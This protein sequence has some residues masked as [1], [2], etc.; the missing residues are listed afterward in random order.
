[1][2]G[3]NF[4]YLV[5]QGVVSVW[6]NRLMSFASFCIIMVSLLLISLAALIA[7]DINVVIGTAED[8]NEILVYVDD[9][10][11]EKIVKIEEALKNNGYTAQVVFYPK[12]E[13]LEAKKEELKEYADLLDALKDNP[14]PDT[15][16]VTIKDISKIDEAKRTFEAIE[17]VSEVSAPYD[18]ASVLVSLKTTLGIIGGAMLIALVVVCIVIVY[19]ASRTSVFARRKEI[20]IM[21]MVGATNS[22]IKLPFFIEGMFIGILAGAVSWFLTKIAYEA[23]ISFFAGDLTIWKVLGL[24]NVIPFSEV[25]WYL[26][27]FNCA[28]GAI[29]SA[30]GTIFSMGKH[31]KV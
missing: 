24:S 12:E 5:K 3:S 19:N 22:F 15:F 14:M 25:I 18:F 26:L 7:A 27:A 28:A 17:G 20:G 16:R 13:A 4:S 1:M 29:L 10:D 2:R 21:K 31:L 30:I 23:L 8:K 9:A 6:H 11:D